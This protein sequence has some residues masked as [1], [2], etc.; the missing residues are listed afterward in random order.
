MAFASQT[1]LPLRGGGWV[2]GPFLTLLIAAVCG[3][4]ACKPNLGPPG[5]LIT[6]LRVLAIRGDP[7]EVRPGG[8]DGGIEYDLLA[9]TPD[10][11]IIE[12]QVTWSYCL[13]PTPPAD[14]DLVS[15]TCLGPNADLLAISSGSS[16]G[17]APVPENS[18]SVFGP[19]PPAPSD[20][21][22][23]RPPD[24]DGTGGY[25]QPVRA[26]L[27][28]SDGGVVTSFGEE[29]IQCG[30]PNVTIAVATAYQSYTLNQNPVLTGV[31]AAVGGQASVPLAA[32]D[33]GPGPSISA[34][35]SVTFTA[36]WPDSSAES[37]PV[38][39]QVQRQVVTQR[40]NL[41]SS[42]FVTG[43]ALDLDEVEVAGTDTSTTASNQWT[44][45]TT[46]G[47]VH[48]WVIL[49]DSRGGV[50]FGEFVVTVQ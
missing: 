28:L 26:D 16:D 13:A 10:G 45:P 44:A 18:C 19:F 11:T 8:V 15:Q 40:E 48:L 36:S 35:T 6:G 42:W 3:A 29:R 41:I 1:P 43:G 46:S 17:F 25:Y 32:P 49:R 39:D 23:G 38:F 30:L 22:A 21:G 20:A 24:P 12:P 33:A 47:P 9:V 27:A 50:D 31:S 4:L 2:R 5:S 34:G 14:N 37:F 7:P